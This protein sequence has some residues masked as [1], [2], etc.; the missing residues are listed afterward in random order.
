MQGGDPTAGH[1]YGGWCIGV[2]HSDERNGRSDKGA[3][4]DGRTGAKKEP[5]CSGGS[6]RCY[7]FFTIGVK[8]DQ[9]SILK[10]RMSLTDCTNQSIFFKASIAR[11]TEPSPMSFCCVLVYT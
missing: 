10:A 9:S 6:M 2:P 5:V 8:F 1:F 7:L 3:E 11:N 4:P